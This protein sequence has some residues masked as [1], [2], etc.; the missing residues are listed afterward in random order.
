MKRTASD[1][2]G[3]DIA[4]DSSVSA[5][6]LPLDVWRIIFQYSSLQFL[7]HPVCRVCHSAITELLHTVDPQQQQRRDAMIQQWICDVADDRTDNN[8]RDLP[9]LLQWCQQLRGIPDIVSLSFCRD[10]QR[11]MDGRYWLDTQA[12]NKDNIYLIWKENKFAMRVIARD[13]FKHLLDSPLVRCNA[14]SLTAFRGANSPRDPYETHVLPG[15]ADHCIKT[16]EDY[17]NTVTRF[18]YGVRTGDGIDAVVRYLRR[19]N[20]WAHLYDRVSLEYQLMIKSITP[21]RLHSLWL[22]HCEPFAA[23]TELTYNDMVARGEK[24]W[25]IADDQMASDVCHLM[26]N[27]LLVVDARGTR[28]H[29]PHA[30]SEEELMSAAEENDDDGVPPRR[31]YVRLYAPRAL[32][33][34]LFNKLPSGALWCPAKSYN[35]DFYIDCPITDDGDNANGFGLR[36]YRRVRWPYMGTRENRI[37]WERETYGLDRV[38]GFLDV[39]LVEIIDQDV[40]RSNGFLFT[41][42]AN[43]F[44]RIPP[45]TQ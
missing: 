17:T 10:M 18:V 25:V 26:R 21:E 43:H 5:V 29:A 20:D 27:G 11:I 37:Q 8:T 1:L 13:H 19:Q 41:A 12:T 36:R 45:S 42:L 7:F 2:S 9:E 40:D 3:D 16:V 34:S 44:P 35:D 31:A 14:M 33:L 6:I 30:Y 22:K 32:L 24:H 23:N 39:Q 38:P 4:V 15:D 28:I